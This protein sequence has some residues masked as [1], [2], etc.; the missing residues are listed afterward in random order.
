MTNSSVRKKEIL[1]T[2]ENC[3]DIHLFIFGK[4]GKRRK[5]KKLYYFMN[6]KVRIAETQLMTRRV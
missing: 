4:K 3:R 1:Q 6:F 2:C 5:I